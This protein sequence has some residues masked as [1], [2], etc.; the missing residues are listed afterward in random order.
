MS[1]NNLLQLQRQVVILAGKIAQL[2][3]KRESKSQSFTEPEQTPSDDL[4][5]KIEKRMSEA[6]ESYGDAFNFVVREN[7]SLYEDHTRNVLSWR[8]H[9]D[10]TLPDRID[11]AEQALETHRAHQEE[12][13]AKLN[14]YPPDSAAL[15]L[16]ERAKQLA[17]EKGMK[18]SDAMGAVIS[19]NPQ[20]YNQHVQ[21]MT[22]RARP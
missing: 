19:K 3:E 6:G 11:I 14:D 10:R 7:P 1:T 20:L 4:Q 13:R 2:E 8:E 9:V 17:D 5:A 12:T 21:Q 18:Y 22:L 15:K 16:H